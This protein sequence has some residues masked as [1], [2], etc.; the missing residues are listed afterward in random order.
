[1]PRLTGPSVLSSTVM[2]SNTVHAQLYTD[3]QPVSCTVGE[4]PASNRNGRF[5]SRVEHLRSLFLIL[6]N[7]LL[8]HVLL[9]VQPGVLEVPSQGACINHARSAR[10][11]AW[12]HGPVPAMDDVRLGRNDEPRKPVKRVRVSL[13]R[14]LHGRA[15]VLF[16]AAEGRGGWN[17]SDCEGWGGGRRSANM[18]FCCCERSNQLSILVCHA[19]HGRRARDGIGVG[20]G[21]E[22]AA[23][24]DAD[25]WRH[26]CRDGRGKLRGGATHREVP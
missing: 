17:R 12:W 25:L 3:Q 20:R 11:T 26:A 8:V 5:V 13:L 16:W 14:P 22:R 23:A 10:Q 19:S 21:A 1:M 18:Q 15:A 2:L 6:L 24:A 9:K 4:S 7:L